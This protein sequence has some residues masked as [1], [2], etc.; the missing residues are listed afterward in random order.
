MSWRGAHGYRLL[1]FVSADSF[2]PPKLRLSLYRACA[3]IRGLR[4]TYLGCI[5]GRGFVVYQPCRYRQVMT[6]LSCRCVMR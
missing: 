5:R 6:G 1:S 2:G 4:A 3:M